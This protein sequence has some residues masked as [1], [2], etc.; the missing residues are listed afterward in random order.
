VLASTRGEAVAKWQPE[1][2]E[3]FGCPNPPVFMDDRQ[4]RELAQYWRA[5]DRVV[6]MGT[7][8]ER[9]DLVRLNAWANKCK[10]DVSLSSLVL[11]STGGPR[12]A[13]DCQRMRRLSPLD[14]GAGLSAICERCKKPGFF[15]RAWNQSANGYGW[16]WECFGDA[17]LK[18]SEDPIYQASAAQTSL[19]AES[20]LRERGE[21]QAKQ[22]DKEL[23]DIYQVFSGEPGLPIK[24]RA[25]IAAVWSG[26]GPESETRIARKQ[27]PP[28]KPPVI[29]Q[30]TGRTKRS[31]DEDF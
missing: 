5:G 2:M 18:R 31:Y 10:P 4:V 9:D 22:I 24:S 17:P 13:F 1:F 27:K 14:I 28:P 7:W 6:C 30:I 8:A 26:E 25:E 3:P 12:M 29:Q 16:F 21:K 19:F 20:L 15:H 11:W 23:G